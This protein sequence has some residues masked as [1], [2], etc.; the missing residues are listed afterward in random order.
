MSS[1]VEKQRAPS[2]VRQ[3][4]LLS[5]F[6]RFGFD[7]MPCSRCIDKGLRCLWI[8]DERSRSKRCKE[9]VSAS[10]RCDSS[11]EPLD[12]GNPLS[13]QCWITLTSSVDRVV[14]EDKRLEREENEALAGLEEASRKA[15]DAIR[16]SQELSAR[17]R[18]LRKQRQLMKE[19]GLKMVRDGLEDMDA[20][21]A[22]EEEERR[23]L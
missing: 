1:R 12:S 11:G 16:R 9:C 15:E 3:Y 6:D 7:V 17:L 22:R 4:K 5:A 13:P 10:A 23:A 19:K 20:L 8:D 21:E 18:R 14:Y 2:T